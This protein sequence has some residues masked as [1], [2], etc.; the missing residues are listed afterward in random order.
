MFILA[1]FAGLVYA[2]VVLAVGCLSMAIVSLFL[3]FHQEFMAV[4]L[5]W[6]SYAAVIIGGFVAGK[7]YK[8]RGIIVGGTVG[9]V[10]ILAILAIGSLGAGGME[11]I[12]S[13]GM[14]ERIA[15]SLL[16]GVLGGVLG[17]NL[18]SSS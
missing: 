7:R 5:T 13:T 9:M 16:A 18:S 10:Y 6:I 3:D 2:W 8:R 1:I 4:I 11:G 17:V 14:L 15:L 12:A